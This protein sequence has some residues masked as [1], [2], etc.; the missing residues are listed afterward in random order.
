M[1]KVNFKG[2][3]LDFIPEEWDQSKVKNIF[4]IK[5][6]IAGKVGYAIISITKKGAKIK[7]IESGE[8]Q[9]SM[10]YSKY[11]L[12]NIGDFLMNHMD[13]LTGFIDISKFKGVTSPD[14]RVFSIKKTNFLVKRKYLKIIL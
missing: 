2:D 12:V 5:K 13:L 7:D 4:D 10:D 3:W 8:G 9:L 14:Y 6:V 11:Q 1:C